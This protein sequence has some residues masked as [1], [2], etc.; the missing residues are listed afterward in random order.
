[1]IAW[2]ETREQAIE[3]ALKAAESMVVEGVKTNLPLHREILKDEV[4]RAGDTPTSYLEDLLQR[5]RAKGT[6][7]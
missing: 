7:K 4:F 5:L 1:V 6:I 3:R 2:G